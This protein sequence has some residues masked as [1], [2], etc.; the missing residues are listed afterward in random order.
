VAESSTGKVHEFQI[1]LK[2]GFKIER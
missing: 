1:T 2:G